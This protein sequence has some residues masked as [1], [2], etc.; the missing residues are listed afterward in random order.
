MLLLA[1]LALAAEPLD[2]GIIQNSDVRVV[3]RMLYTKANRFE[4][5]VHLA[6]MPFDGFTVTPQLALTGVRHF[7]EAIGV[8][9]QLG[10][11]YGLKTGRYT[12]L[13][14][15]A[16]GVAVEA[17]RYLASAEVD[18]QWSPIYAK[19]NF[20]G[21]KILHNDFYGLVGVGATLEQSVFPSADITIAPTVP[22]GIGTRIWLKDN[23]ALRVEI[24]DNVMVEHRKTSDTVAMKQ[25]VAV[26]VGLAF[27]N[28]AK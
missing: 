15:P 5:G 2:V 6:A 4:L 18:L 22:V 27:L 1:S 19:M 17:Y 9:L 23:L 8:E 25:N 13:E 20:G 26:S 3:Q 11:G 12:E 16:Y 21:H 14:G 24:R 7:S 10:G 28:K